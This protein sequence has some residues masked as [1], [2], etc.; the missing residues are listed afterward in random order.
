MLQNRPILFSTFIIS[1]FAITLVS[2]P[3]LVA[4]AFPIIHL[5]T[6]GKPGNQKFEIPTDLSGPNRA[7]CEKVAK[8][9]EEFDICSARVCT[10]PP[11]GKG[12]ST[13]TQGNRERK[14][15]TTT[16]ERKLL[17]YKEGEFAKQCI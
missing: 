5:C 2:F 11:R 14:C 16:N 10:Y 17:I 15:I 7:L 3:P 8:A 9:C 1:L 13:V 6:E 12:E 4:D